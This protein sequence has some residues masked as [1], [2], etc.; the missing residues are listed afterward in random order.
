MIKLL[1][2]LK[3]AIPAVMF[4]TFTASVLGAYS[5]DKSKGANSLAKTNADYILLN[6]NNITVPVD[7]KGV[8]AEVNDLGGRSDGKIFLF[9]GGFFLSGLSGNKQW[10]NGVMSASRIADYVAGPVG[11]TATDSKNRMYLVTALDPAFGPSWQDWKDA[12]AVGADFYDGDHDGVYNPVD[13]NQNGVWDLDEDRPDLVGDFTAWCVYNDG[14]AKAL[15]RFTDVDPQGIEIRQSVFGFSSKSV[16]GNMLF[17]RYRVVNTGLKN[18]VM[19]SVYFSVACDPDLGDYKDDLVGCDTALS[20]A[21][22]Y[23]SG[24][25]NIWGANPPCF[26]V[27]FFQGPVSYVPGITFTDKNGNGVYDDGIDIPLKSATNVRGK[28]LG[29]DTIKGAMNLPLSSFTQYMQ[30]HPTHGDP[31]TQYELRNYLIGGRGKDGLPVNPCTWAFGNGSTLPDCKTINPKFMYSGDPVK[32]AG[33]L[34]TTPQD[35]RQMSNTGPFRLE[36]GK[37]VDIVVAYLIGRGNTA[38]NSVEVAKQNDVISQKIFDANFPS[39]EPPVP[40]R[41]EVVT[42][43]GFIDINWNTPEQ[44]KYRKV[45]DVLGLD[46]QFRGYYVTAYST[47]SKA[48]QING[49]QNSQVLAYYQ[50]AFT[51]SDSIKGIYTV[52]SN[53]G[54]ELRMPESPENNKLDSALYADPNTGRIKLRVTKDPVTGGPLVKGK[55]YFFVVTN[56]TLNYKY[57]VNNN[58]KVNDGRAADY[59]DQTGSGVDEFESQMMRCVYGTDMYDPSIAG[60]SGKHNTGAGDGAFKYI[61]ADKTKLTGN[62]YKV[63]MFIDSAST[64]Y[65]TYWRLTNSTTNTVLIDSS[66]TYNFDTTN[67]SGK[68]IEGF[69]PRVKPVTPVLGSPVYTPEA[70][71]WFRD[72]IVAEGHGVFYKGADLTAGNFLDVSDF[73][74]RSTFMRADRMRKIEVRFGKTSK[75]YRFLTGYKGSAIVSRGSNTYGEGV[76]A[77]DTVG[78]GPVGKLGQ[79]FVDVPYQVWVKD[80]KYN[81]ERQLA[82]AFTERRIDLKGNPDGVWNPQDKLLDNKEYIIVLDA[83]YDPNGAQKVY[84]GGKFAT[85]S[86]VDSTVW[87]DIIKGYTIPVTATGVSDKDRA[88][89]RSPMF[90]TM[91]VIGFKALDANAHWTD[92][93]ILSVPIMTY[94]YTGSDQFTFT[95]A[96]KGGMGEDLKKDLFEKVTVFPNPLFAYNP[97]TSYTVGAY[98]D[99]PFVTFSNLPTEVTVKIYTLAGTLIRTLT[100]TDKADGVSAPFLRWN[101]KNE[102]G[103]RV[104]SGMYIARVISPKYG[105]KILKFGIVMPQ[106]QIRNY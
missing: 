43:D 6:Y 94:P 89:A 80:S 86:G 95:T 59:L 96:L 7:N 77:T 30:S 35:Q 8:I 53:G 44:V 4:L 18:D 47:Q 60:N 1:F 36:K 61:V 101:L 68:I 75:A 55:E 17:V 72:F 21:F 81:E 93:D 34:N 104:A 33:W 22:T 99:D 48:D 42:G 28:T 24:T 90:N 31:A 15:R 11:S 12:V 103:L 88:I 100:Q 2:R 98:P 3:G 76:S 38:L 49:I 66:K 84:T 79:G 67:Y 27:D 23:Q 97:A 51:K 73:G 45:D 74:G 52:L 32:G 85:A 105:E 64:T 16:I 9:S 37:P 78:K 29:I 57:L 92:G 106:K 26:M 14:L 13:K 69:L 87:G 19:D 82:T 10:G 20:C 50:K 71:Q 62:N 83:D 46:R 5:G 40:V 102:S 91:Y 39:P 54:T 25:D 65:S 56:Y 58:S 70:N 41:P 63:D